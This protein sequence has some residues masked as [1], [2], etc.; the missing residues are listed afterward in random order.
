MIY[1]IFLSNICVGGWWWWLVCKVA[2]YIKGGT[3]IVG[4]RH[5]P[6]PNLG[7]KYRGGKILV[8]VCQKMRQKRKMKDCCD[9]VPCCLSDTFRSTRCD[10]ISWTNYNVSNN[11]LGMKEKLF[12]STEPGPGPLKRRTFQYSYCFCKA[13]TILIFLPNSKPNSW[14]KIIE[15]H[16]FAVPARIC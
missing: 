14:L 2:P 8:G 15:R 9:G 4:N 16:F 3:P 11:S 1:H 5:L 13:Q 6:I 12:F 10:S 7:T